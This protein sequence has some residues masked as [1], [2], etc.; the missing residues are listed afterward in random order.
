MDAT[1]ARFEE[2]NESI[3]SLRASTD[4]LSRR[5]AKLE[6]EV[7]ECISKARHHDDRLSVQNDQIAIQDGDDATPDPSLS[8]HRHGKA[9]NVHRLPV[10]ASRS[11]PMCS[12]PG[13]A[14]LW[15]GG[16]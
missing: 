13:S 6:T 3:S 7:G 12:M 1:E 15:M 5:A 4:S 11:P 14:Q 2:V 8:V 10:T 9:A 16:A